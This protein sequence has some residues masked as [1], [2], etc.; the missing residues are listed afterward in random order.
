M[1]MMMMMTMMMMMMMIMMMMMM[2]MMIRGL[3]IQ[4]S[5]FLSLQQSTFLSPYAQRYIPSLPLFVGGKRQH[6]RRWQLPIGL[7]C[8]HSVRQWVL[9]YLI[10]E[11][12]PAKTR[13][14]GMTNSE[15]LPIIS[16]PNQMPSLGI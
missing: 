16:Q 13:P 1:M 2:L 7:P 10:R 4:A 3:V 6:L 14:I 15:L 5:N 8:A 11:G 12:T 9:T